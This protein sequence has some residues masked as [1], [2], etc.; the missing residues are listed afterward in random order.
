[1]KALDRQKKTKKLRCTWYP[2]RPYEAK[3]DHVFAWLD[4]L[5]SQEKTHLI[6]QIT[7]IDLKLVHKLYS[8]YAEKVAYIPEHNLVPSPVINI[9]KDVADLKNERIAKKIGEY[10]L[11]KG[12]IA[13]ITV[14]GGD[15]TRL[16]CNGTKGSLPIAPISQKSIFQL[17]AEKICALQQR[18]AT[19][20]PW[21]IMTSKTNEQFTQNFF[22]I[23]Q[24]FGLDCDQIRLF[25]QGM[26]PVLNLHGKILMN[27]RSNIVMSPNGHGGLISA[28]QD[29]GIFYDMKM[30]GIK[31]VFY[32]QVDNVLTKIADP[33]FI[34]YHIKESADM[35]LKV[36]KKRHPDEKVGVV[37]CVDGKL[38]VVEYSELSR[39]N[40]YAKNNDGYLKFDAGNIAVHMI[41]TG[42]LEKVCQQ[43]EKML[44]YHTAVKIV[45]YIDEHGS[46]IRPEKNNA[47]KFERFIFDMLKHAGKCVVMEVKREEE[48]SPVKNRV[49]EDSP[50]TAMRDMVNLF[51]KLLNQ[52]GMFVPVDNY[53]NVSGLIE[54]NPSLALDEEAL[55][56]KIQYKQFPSNRF[57]Y[58]E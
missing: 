58:L 26:L 16:G 4:D 7:S 52:A 35:S 14:A 38:R 29:A 40:M 21:Y 3:Q 11:Q 10:S 6:E 8:D 37:A 56:N 28:L 47:L 57:L 5:P 13:V 43:S 50:I 53:G 32:H 15:G 44:P 54:I 34:G 24:H 42:F 45:P 46:L 22:N 1:M 9:P 33:V 27:S 36:V 49:G 20:I 55:R 18:Y 31:Y 48:F 30:R 25:T 41:S 23:H 19:K 12:E 51:G 2:T 39:E 17:H